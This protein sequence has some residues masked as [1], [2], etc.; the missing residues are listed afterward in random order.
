VEGLAVAVFSVAVITGLIYGL[1]ELVPVVSTGV[2]YMLAVLL[3]SIYWGL[4]L[5]LLTALLSAA[6]W[7]FFHIPPTSEF[8]IAD[9]E[10]WVALAV[11]FIAATAISALAG[12]ARS[13]AD[14]AEARRREAD[15]TADMAR[16][17]LGGSVLD[18]SLR[19][20]GRAIGAA[21]G[22]GSV[23][24]DLAWADSDERRRALPL[25]VDGSRV[26]T[27]MVPRDTDEATLDTLQDR[28]LPA[29][30]TLVGAARKREE[31][32]AQVIETKALRRSNVVKTAV[33]R[34]V[35]H[36]LRS[37][38]TAI[39]TAAA[40]LSSETLAPAERDELASVI[41]EESARLSRLVDNLLDLSRLQAG[42]VEPHADWCA[43]DELVRAAIDH[44]PEPRGGYDVQL[45]AD[46]PLVRVD[47]AQ[48]E[49]ALA[50]V[51]EN[52]TR[53]AGTDPV[54]VRARGASNQ[55]LLR[56]GDRGPGIP[57]EELE[58]IFEAFHSPGEQSGTGLGLAIARG[59]IEANGGRIRAESLPG[60]G[61]TIVVTLPVP[62]QQPAELPAQATGAE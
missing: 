4:A 7:N 52:A 38:L 9:G 57:R 53:F 2:V 24:I 16:L 50:N 12:A 34:S 46:L 51:I 44:V 45:E 11:F 21:F 29:L 42:S 61:T 35:S 48:L 23:G 40:G 59:F 54:T 55:L 19:A 5:G 49:R 18:D 13:R 37:P 58:R 33:L 6:A 17:L 10:H 15:L 47:A 22:I 27:V 8:T 62:A 43:V 25:L 28:V 14:E 41:A 1:R 30:E 36:D 3:V 32:E 20:A 26:G 60:Q 39:T 31:L 56:I